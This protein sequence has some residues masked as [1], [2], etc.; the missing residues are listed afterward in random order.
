M[1][2]PKIHSGLTMDSV[3]PHD[4]CLFIVVDPLS[5]PTANATTK[6]RHAKSIQLQDTHFGAI[7]HISPETIEKIASGEIEELYL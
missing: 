7:I 5:M 2:N 1:F 6:Y 4:G 3:E